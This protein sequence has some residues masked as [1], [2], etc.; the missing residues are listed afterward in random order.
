MFN[1]YMKNMKL[2]WSFII[3]LMKIGGRGGGLLGKLVFYDNELVK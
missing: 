2:L 3:S 1:I